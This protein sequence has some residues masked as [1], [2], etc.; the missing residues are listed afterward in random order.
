MNVVLV[1]ALL[2]LAPVGLVLVFLCR[3]ILS[4]QKSTTSMDELLIL[5]PAKFRPM[6]RLLREDDFKFLAA[7]PG[8]SSRLGRRF[9][10]ERR[11]VFRVYLR[12]LSE[13]F[14]RVALACHLLM[15]HSAVD[16]RDLASALL[17]QRLT[18]ALGM[19]A[20]EGRLLLHAAG[21]GTVDVRGLVASLGAVQDQIRAMAAIPQIAA[22]TL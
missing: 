4:R 3:T 9:R 20:I 5:S 2:T 13:D 19:L 6:E 8:Y 21:I 12:N 22:A 10:S 1:I 15:I 18:F 17:R 14:R 16:R 11:R 7:Q